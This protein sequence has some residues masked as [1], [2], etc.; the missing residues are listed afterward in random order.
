MNNRIVYQR[1]SYLFKPIFFFLKK[2][3]FL[4]RMIKIESRTVTVQNVGKTLKYVPFQNVV[5]FILQM[6]S[7]NMTN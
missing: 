2:M 5:L 6:F 1:V 3:G 7:G 4:L